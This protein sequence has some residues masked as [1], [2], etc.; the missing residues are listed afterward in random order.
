M[1]QAVQLP[2]S[3]MHEH[4]PVTVSYRHALP[5]DAEEVVSLVQSAYR[6][7]SSREG[8]TTEAD[9]LEGQR[10][11]VRAVRVAIE[12]TNSLVLLATLEGTTVGCCQLVDHGSVTDFGLFAVRPCLQGKT[13]G[14]A[15]IA[16]AEHIARLEWSAL[17]M[18]MKVIRQRE[19]LIAWY[20]RR[21]YQ[22]TGEVEPFPYGDGEFVIPLRDDLEFVVLEKW[23]AQ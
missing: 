11:D 14:S 8:W 18:R 13:L 20:R 2:F 19:E 16:E 21:G 7:N 3:V 12:Q 22:P 1:G 6:G 10:T 4:P 23:I 9:L 17:T 5:D 15:L